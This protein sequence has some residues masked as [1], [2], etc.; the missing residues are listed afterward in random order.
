MSSPQGKL[1]RRQ[2]RREE[3]KRQREAR[4]RREQR[5]RALLRVAI[6]AAVAAV[7]VGAVV[8]IIVTQRRPAAPPAGTQARAVPL[9]AAC[10]LPPPVPCPHLDEGARYTRY[11]SDPPTSGPHWPQ[12]ADWGA[13]ERPLPPERLIHNLEHGGIVVYYSC[14]DCPDLV[15]QLKDALK[16]SRHSVLVPYYDMKHRI[17]LTAWGYI[18]ELDTFDR[19]RVLAFIRAYIDRGPER[20][21]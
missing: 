2:E 19:D 17:A 16:G 5:S 3:A 7:V 15:V 6:V 14:R 9:E 12:P 20:V 18:D 4:R 1:E 13:Y 10:N 11:N 21:R 8:A